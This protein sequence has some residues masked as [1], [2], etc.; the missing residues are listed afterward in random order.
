M[1]TIFWERKGVI[2]AEF[3]PKM[4]AIHT[5]SHCITFKELQR[6]SQNGRR[7]LISGVCCTKMLD[8]T[9]PLGHAHYLNSSSRE[10]WATCT[11][12][13]PLASSAQDFLAPGVWLATKRKE[14]YRTDEKLDGE[15]CKIFPSSL[16]LFY[17]WNIKLSMKCPLWLSA[18]LTVC[19]SFTPSRR[20]SL[21]SFHTIWFLSKQVGVRWDAIIFELQVHI[22]RTLLQTKKMNNVGNEIIK[23]LERYET[24]GG[25]F[26]WQVQYSTYSQQ[27]H[28]DLL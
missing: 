24:C 5:E 19:C 18:Y 20:T 14:T 28:T 2:L 12:W 3:L 1:A 21:I 10:F 26:Y 11:K 6:S 16:K 23:C 9:P 8:G 27:G 22:T 7:D 4:K 13:L 25:E 15:N 17:W